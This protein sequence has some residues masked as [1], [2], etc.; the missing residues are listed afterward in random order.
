MTAKMLM[1]TELIGYF[2][3][4]ALLVA[5][6][7]VG[8]YYLY[9]S[10]AASETSQLVK[11]FANDMRTFKDRRSGRMIVRLLK[12]NLLSS[13]GIGINLAVLYLAATYLHLPYSSANLLGM[14]STLPL[15]FVHVRF[16]WKKTGKE[17]EGEQNN[18]PALEEYQ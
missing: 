9:A 3:N 12:F 8:F 14:A 5:L 7:S 17:E 1:R 6:T 10:L 11:F 4:E 13:F 2:I 18:L 16:T 15:Y